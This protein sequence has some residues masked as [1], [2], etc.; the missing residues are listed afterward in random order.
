MVHGRTD[1]LVDMRKSTRRFN[2]QTFL[3]SAGLSNTVI[4]YQRAEVIF[5]QGDRS[6]GYSRSVAARCS[7]LSC[8]EHLP[9]E[10]TS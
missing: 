7:L 10:K 5:S 4:D 2:A 8:R 3:D 6:D 1:I 9:K